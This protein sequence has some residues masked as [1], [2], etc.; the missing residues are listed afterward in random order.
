MAGIEEKYFLKYQRDY[1]ADKSRVKT[2][3]KSRRIGATY[4][5]S[6][7]DVEDC[8]AKPGLSVWFSSA[9][10]SAAKEY[11][12]YCEQWARIF[13]AVAK[14]LGEIVIDKEK[15]I[16]ALAIELANGSRI[17]AL[18]SNPKRFRSKGGKIVLDEFAHHEDQKA[19][20]K[21]ARP[22]ATWGYDIRILSTH[23]GV[24]SLFYKFIEKIKKGKLNWS[25]HTTDIYA[26]VKDGL[27]DKIMGRQLTDEERA[28]WL[29]QEEENCADDLTWQEEYC[30]NALDEGEAFIPYE[31]ISP[32][33]NSDIL[34]EQP[35][36][37]IGDYWLGDG[38][39][40]PQNPKSKWAHDK[41]KIFKQWFLAQQPAGNLFL[42]YD[43]GRRKDLSVIWIWENIY[44]IN[45][46]RCLIVLE[47]MKFWVQDEVLSTCLSHPKLSR[48]CIDETGMGLKIAEDMQD[49]FGEFKVEAIN[50]AAGSVRSEMAFDLKTAFEDKTVKIPDFQE[51]RDDIHSMK[52]F[53]TS[54]NKIRIEQETTDKAGKVIGHA[55]RFWGAA[56]GLHAGKDCAGPI[57]ITSGQA[58][59]VNELL[60]GYK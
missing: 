37:G 53:T 51:V 31:L 5:Q 3:E 14:D 33:E 27:A 16:K 39:F 42:G 21:A 57:I 18:T 30:C 46:C 13:G 29:K 20:W 4:V 17:H 10:E 56:L 12:L 40:E 9:D 48:A 50:F 38:I 58:R 44:G 49:K 25:L 45:I 55:D 36:G 19:M 35:A 32:C 54:G 26:A 8:L 22:S 11:I 52:K 41:I 15:D 43:I 47:K 28:E 7:E 1:L 2:W 6:Y 59:R 23:N 24:S 34:W 60:K